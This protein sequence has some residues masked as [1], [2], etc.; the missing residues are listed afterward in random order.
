MG[1]NRWVAKTEIHPDPGSSLR[2]TPQIDAV[3][4]R[5]A[6]SRETMRREAEWLIGS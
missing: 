2:S 6:A 3:A 5:V 4:D 1:W